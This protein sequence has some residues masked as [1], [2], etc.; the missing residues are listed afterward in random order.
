MNVCFWPEP[1]GRVVAVERP[2]LMKADAQNWEFRN[3]DDERLV[4]ARK[5]SLTC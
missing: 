4:Y 5:Q 2:L 3:R 1:A